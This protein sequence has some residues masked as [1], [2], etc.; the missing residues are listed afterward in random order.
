LDTSDIAH[1]FKLPLSFFDSRKTGEILSRIA[2]ISKI[3]EM[4][5]GTALSLI[6]DCVLIIVI[7]PIL[8]NIDSFLFVVSVSNVVIMSIVV[9]LFSKFFKRYFMQLRIEE[10]EVD[11]SLVEAISGAYTVKALNAEKIIGKIYEEKK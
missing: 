11:S 9:L 4:L 7:G 8:L 6:L 3:Q 10:A 1:I 5:S 2:D